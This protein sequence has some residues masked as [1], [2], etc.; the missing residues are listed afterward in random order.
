MENANGAGTTIGRDPGP[1][2]FWQAEV[3]WADGKPVTEMD[4]VQPAVAELIDG[5]NELGI[6]DVDAEFGVWNIEIY[7]TRMAELILEH[8]EGAYGDVTIA[9]GEYKITIPLH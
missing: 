2:K 7:D 4:M 5:E 1:T 3:Q 9:G 8:I 6:E